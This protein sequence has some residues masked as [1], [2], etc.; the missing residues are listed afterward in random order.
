MP[1]VLAHLLGPWFL[2]LAI[3]MIIFAFIGSP[4]RTT[5]M[6]TGVFTF[7]VISPVSALFM[8]YKLNLIAGIITGVVLFCVGQKLANE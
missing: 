7:M 3:P 6:L 1:I 4:S 2:L 5:K 8:W